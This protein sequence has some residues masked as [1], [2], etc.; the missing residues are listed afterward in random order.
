MVTQI[1]TGVLRHC[2]LDEPRLIMLYGTLEGTT[3]CEAVVA[4]ARA[5]GTEF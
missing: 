1:V 4:A 3:E 5:L 2:G